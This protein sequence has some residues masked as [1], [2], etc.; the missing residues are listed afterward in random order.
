M[1]VRELICRNISFLKILITLLGIFICF[2]TRFLNDRAYDH[3]HDSDH[4]HRVFP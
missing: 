2:R 3:V 4:V 1:F